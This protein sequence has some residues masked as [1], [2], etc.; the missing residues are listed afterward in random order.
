[1]VDMRYFY[2]LAGLFL[3][4][5]AVAVAESFKVDLDVDTYVDAKNPDQSFSDSDTLW[6]ASEGAKPVEEVYLSFINLFE[7]LGIT[8]PEQIGSA[9]LTEKYRPQTPV[10]RPE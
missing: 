9:T 5:A 6:A 2:A 3:M 7:S 10:F 4:L 8:K 1:V